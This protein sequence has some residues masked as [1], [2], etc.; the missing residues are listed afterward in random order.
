MISL[1]NVHQ[2]KEGSTN[3]HSGGGGRTGS[4]ADRLGKWTEF[5]EMGCS[6]TPRPPPSWNEKWVVQVGGADAGRGGRVGLRRRGL[7]VN[8]FVGGDRRESS[9]DLTGETGEAGGA[10][11]VSSVTMGISV[12]GADLR[13]KTKP[14]P[15]W[16]GEIEFGMWSTVKSVM[17][18]DDANSRERL[19]LK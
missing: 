15:V 4:K 14:R 18:D 9:R 11:T 12:N 16:R 19:T 6:V 8:V 17:M 2:L 5:W 3:A 10:S 1:D 7:D 13:V